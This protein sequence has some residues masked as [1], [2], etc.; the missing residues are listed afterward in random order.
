[1]GVKSANL[2][3]TWVWKSK[4]FLKL[5]VKSSNFF[6]TWVWKSQ[7]VPQNGCK[8]AKLVWKEKCK[9][10]THHPV[11]K[12]NT[13][14]ADQWKDPFLVC[15]EMNHVSSTHS[16]PTMTLLLRFKKWSINRGIGAWKNL[17][18]IRQTICNIYGITHGHD[19]TLVR[20]W[21]T[22]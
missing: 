16:M 20:P 18:R 10:K 3:S 5:V 19:N 14:V 7:T 6:S 9:S 2:F 17:F 15:I 12:T 22:A 1:M 13:T 8:K 21:H 4:L 11:C